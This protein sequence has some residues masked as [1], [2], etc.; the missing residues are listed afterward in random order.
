M[1]PKFLLPVVLG[2]ALA[3]CAQANGNTIT[4][5]LSHPTQPATVKVSTLQG[6]ITVTAASNVSGVVLESTGGEQ[7]NR[8]RNPPAEAQGMHLLNQNPGLSAS[9]DNNVVTVSTSAFGGGNLNIQVPVH[10]SLSLHSVNGERIV[11][12]GVQGDINV[13]DTNGN[14]TLNNVGGSIIAHGLNGRVVATI[15]SLDPS[16]PSSFSSLNG[17]IDVTLPATVRA[18][19]R[20]HTDQGD[21]YMDDGFNF[22][23]TRSPSDNS[24]PASTRESNGMYKVRVD[25]TVYGTLN[26]GGPELRFENFNGNIYIRKAH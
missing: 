24:S 13:Q 4:I 19:L 15:V 17:T 9:E 16:K 25:R 2:F 26:G 3:A 11:V 22:Q 1:K 5:P 10:T 21:I 18:N 8:H 14:I 23:P 20:L 7:W 6:T 12:T